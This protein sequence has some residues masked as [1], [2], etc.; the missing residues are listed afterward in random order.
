MLT[1][2]QLKL[3]EFINERV[4]WDGVPP[5]FE[6]MKVAMKL[7]SKSGIHRLV[8]ALEERGYLRR[9]PNRARAIEVIKF[10]EHRGIL[11]A[12]SKSDAKPSLPFSGRLPFPMSVDELIVPLM[13]RIAAGSPIEAIS[14]KES[15]VV[16]PKIMT[17]GPGEH[18][19]LTVSGDSMKDEGIFDEDTVIIRKQEHADNGEIVVALVRGEEVTLKRLRRRGTSIAL[20]AAN[21]EYPIQMY[22]P[23]EVAVQGKLVGLLRSY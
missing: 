12:N 16:V 4:T 2:K 8:K 6:E 11:Q 13:G 20:E 9:L 1:R 22:N 15:E 3:L 14:R 7:R 18:F 19:A 23:S 5:S 17:S 10:P 21:P